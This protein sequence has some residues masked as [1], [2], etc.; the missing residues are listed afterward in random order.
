[1]QNVIKKEKGKNWRILSV[2]CSTGEEP[3]ELAMRALSAGCSSFSIDAI[4]VSESVIKVAQKGEY[5]GVILG[6]KDFLENMAKRNLVTITPQTNDSV[7][8]NI[9]QEVKDRVNFSTR[10]IVDTLL[11]SN[12][13]DIVIC[14]NVLQYY[15]TTEREFMV[16]RMLESLKDQG[17][18]L[19]EH[20]HTVPGGANKEQE[21]F[22]RTFIQWQHDLSKLGLS[23]IEKDGWLR[24]N[25]YR[26]DASS[27]QYKGKRLAIQ[28]D[29][30][31]DADNPPPKKQSLI[32]KLLRK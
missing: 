24:F 5:P 32:A 18:F 4:D 20:T 16:A 26:Y 11:P 9:A 23:R 6:A 7:S 27:N 1:M 30:L 17:I 15:S 19:T 8:A 22:W 2:G 10:N 28:N 12:N 29:M 25:G 21:E 3:Y 31:I 14:N 13:Y